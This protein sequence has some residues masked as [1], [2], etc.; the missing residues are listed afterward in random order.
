MSRRCRLVVLALTLAVL[1]PPPQSAEQTPSKGAT[2]SEWDDGPVRYIMNREEIKVFRALKDDESRIRFIEQFWQRRDPSPS[3][4]D[5]EYRNLFWGR[6]K[7]ANERLAD[8]AVPGWKTDR[9]K[10]Y[11]LC[12]EPDKIENHVNAETKSG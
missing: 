4:P 11:V 7:Y 1:F 12:G 3:T 2:P 9:G 10:M 6:V 8:S 5:N